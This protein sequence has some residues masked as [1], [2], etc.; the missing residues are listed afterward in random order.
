[1]C[2]TLQYLFYEAIG[3]VEWLLVE[4]TDDYVAVD[5][6]KGMFRK[7][8]VKELRSLGSNNHIEQICHQQAF[9]T[10]SMTF[11]PCN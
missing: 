8:R 9:C 1:V 6:M 11:H 10:P 2:S 5:M 3:P 4:A 7:G